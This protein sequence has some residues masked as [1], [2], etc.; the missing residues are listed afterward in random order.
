MSLSG[1]N[2]MLHW[3]EFQLVPQPATGVVKEAEVA[4]LTDIN[5]QTA[6]A[7]NGDCHVVG[8]KASIRVDQNQSWVLNGKKGVYLRHHEQG[9]YDIVAIGMREMY[10]KIHALIKSRCEDINREARRI[11]QEIQQQTDHCRQRYAKQTHHGGNRAVQSAWEA[12]IKSIKLSGKGVLAD[13]PN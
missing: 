2:H 6:I 10:N 4:V 13:L 11:Q 12:Q 7:H 5:W 8:I 3:S 1:F 9:H